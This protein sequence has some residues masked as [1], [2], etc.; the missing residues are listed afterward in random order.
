MA[1]STKG[2]VE[3][4]G[5]GM[6]KTIAPGNHTLKINS[7]Y[8]EEYSFI[9]DSY[10]LYMNV[11]TKPIEG[12]EGFL[13]DPNIQDGLRYEG[14]VGRVKAS[15]YAFADGQTKTGIQIQR[16]KSLLIFLQNLCKALDINDW[17]SN[18]DG[19]HDSIEA[20][21]K[22]FNT[23]A[24]FRGKYMDFCIAGKEYKGK[25]EYINYDMWLP[26]STRGAYAFSEEGSS[27][28]MQYSAAEHLTKLEDSAPAP[29]FKATDDFVFETKSNNDFTLD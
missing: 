26:K 6:P 10:H 25:A 19:K 23:E 28:V 17:F 9:P 4:N 5:G 22:A 20:F 16:D 18:Q 21:V 15:K 11:E 13:I 24:P 12:F 27:K 1:L 2:L 8:L 14:Q 29:T 3:N 7:V